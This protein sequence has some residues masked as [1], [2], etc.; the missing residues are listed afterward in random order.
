MARAFRELIEQEQEFPMKV[1]GAK[2]LPYTSRLLTCEPRAGTFVLKLFRPLPAALATGARF[3]MV[4]ASGD[5]RYEGDVAFLGQVG[6]L[7]Y[8]FEWPKLLV[9][10]DRRLWKRYT[11]RPREH[12]HI[13]AQDTG[14]PS[15]GLSGPLTNLSTGGCCFRVDRMVRLDDGLP[16]RP[17]GGLLDKGTQ[18]SP[19][20][21]HDLTRTEVLE[22][23]GVVARVQEVDSEVF[24][25][26]K[27]TAMSDRVRD[28]LELLLGA[29]ERRPAPAAAAPAARD[30]QPREAELSDDETPPAEPEP[31]AP[32]AVPGSAALRRLDRRTARILVV[33]PEG[34]SQ[35]ALQKRLREAGFWRLEMTGDLFSAHSRFQAAG[36]APYRLLVVD[37]EPSV[38]EGLDP[39]G[40][41][42]HFEP[43]MRSFGDLPLAYATREPDPLLQVLD[44]AT[45][46]SFASADPDPDRPAR[47]LD[48]LLAFGS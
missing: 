16:V 21:I 10:S 24:L 2:T 1:K 18:L 28:L 12:V 31:E 23:R 43:L 33:S 38:R 35:A 17:N 5:T 27:F 46:T 32:A 9:S 22:V 48:R 39:V 19:I 4:F 3:E 36:P 44:T 34:E 47:I 45:Q 7:Q 13:T 29:R 42:R 14:T 15:H 41:I 25:G 40:A 11:F 26:I 8:Q 20:K 37:L 6:Y 30:A